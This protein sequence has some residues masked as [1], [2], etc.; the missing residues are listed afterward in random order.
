MKKQLKKEEKKERLRFLKKIM[1]Y[2]LIMA[3][4]TTLGALYICYKANEITGAVITPLC[5]LWSIELSLSA[6]IKIAE[7][8]E[9]IKE[10][11]EEPPIFDEGSI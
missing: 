6:W 2:S 4:I 5:G 3:T 8:K 9:N 10:K 7:E 11:K 1:I